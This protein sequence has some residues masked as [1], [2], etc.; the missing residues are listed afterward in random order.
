MLPHDPGAYSDRAGVHG[1]A[2][3]EA[4]GEVGKSELRQVDPVTGAVIRAVPLP[5]D[6]F[7]EGIA[8]VGD[9]I[10]RL[11]YRDGVAIEWD[12]ESFYFAGGFPSGA[13]LGSVS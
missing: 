10:W 11:T 3:S 5:N 4:I 2:R 12:K 1:P 9:S 6:Y 13:R 7:G 8:V